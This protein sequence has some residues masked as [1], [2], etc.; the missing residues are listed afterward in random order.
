MALPKSVTH[1]QDTM[2]AKIK[3]G[4]LALAVTSLLGVFQAS[5]QETAVE[6]SRLGKQESAHFEKEV[7]VK[8]ELDYLLYLP[9]DLQCKEKWPLMVFSMERVKEDLMLKK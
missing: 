9:A 6:A 5:S 2:N 3:T 4:A 7:V 1:R 8:H